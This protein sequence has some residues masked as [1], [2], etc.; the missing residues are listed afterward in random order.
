LVLIIT[1]YFRG[2]AGLGLNSELGTPSMDKVKE[3]V[4]ENS[5]DFSG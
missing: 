5:D 3:V 4:E 1:T 2:V